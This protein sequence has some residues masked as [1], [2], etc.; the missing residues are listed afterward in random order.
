[1][2]I[3]IVDIGM[4][5]ETAPVEVRECLARDLGNPDKVL[6]SMKEVPSINESL[7]ISTCNRVEVLFTTSDL[8]KSREA[9][10]TLF[11]KLGG[12][13]EES[14]SSSLYV[15][16]NMEAVSH[17]F[18]VASSLDSM[19]LGEPQILGQIKEAYSRATREKRTGVILNRL[20]H[21]AFRVAKRVR[22]ETGI[23]DAAVSVSYAA[24]EMAKKI[25]HDLSGKKALLIGAG[26]MAELAAKHLL[27]HGVSSISVANRTFE[28]AVD[29]AGVFRGTPVSFDEITAQLLEVDIVIS[30]TASQNYVIT[31][32]KVKSSLRKRKNKPIF[33][34]D[35]AVPRDV[36]PAIN[37]LPNAYV[38]DIDDLK[39]LVQLNIAQREQEALKAERI[40]QEEVI[41]FGKWLETLEV[42]PTIISLKEKAE[43]IR[44]A[45]LKRTL[46]N[47]GQFSPAE[48]KALE[49]MTLS[50]TE[51]M[52]NDPILLL[53]RKAGRATR[54]LYLDVA[55]K[56]FN[57]DQ[58]LGE[59]E[60]GHQQ[61]DK[62]PET[63]S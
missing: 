33:F 43:A 20:L 41:K 49:T 7:F 18:R 2:M 8:G 29:L 44:Q 10:L 9:V 13:A 38:Y 60:D 59:E 16:Q 51:K 40:V 24:V 52:I 42:V 48:L 11:S 56:L 46:P 4:N 31:Q 14:F 1:M 37:D 6:I 34:I 26:E 57:L 61:D 63:T 32:E 39:G 12:M 3:T 25:F 54:E 27:S 23:S 45:E 53:K 5:H 50:I 62:D 19:V 22:T 30:S 21:K 58:D 15:H 28:R 35:I 36:E 55:R 17:V 47:L